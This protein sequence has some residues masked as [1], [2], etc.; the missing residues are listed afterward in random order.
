MAA[1]SRFP[2]LAQGLASAHEDQLAQV[3]ILGA[4]SGLHWD[5]LDVD[6][7]VPELLAGLFGTKAYMARQAGRAKSVAKA[8][9]ARA[10]GAKGGRPKR[11]VAVR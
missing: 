9:A 11:T 8:K 6:L 5:M 7:G 4:G 1:F 2:H 3:E 10:N